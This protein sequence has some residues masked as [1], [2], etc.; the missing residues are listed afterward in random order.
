MSCIFTSKR[1]WTNYFDLV[2]AVAKESQ[3]IA[4]M[5]YHRL[6]MKLRLWSCRSTSHQSCPSKFNI[7]YFLFVD[8]E[9][10]VILDY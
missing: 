5:Q 2:I 1:Q 10:N 3:Q 9:G 4:I 8:S 7:K 6:V